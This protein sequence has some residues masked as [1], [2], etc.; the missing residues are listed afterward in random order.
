MP[1]SSTTSMMSVPWPRPAV[2]SLTTTSHSTT[3]PCASASRTHCSAA[4]AMPASSPSRSIRTEVSIAI[5]DG[6]GVDRITRR[7][8]AQFAHDV[9]GAHAFGQLEPAAGAGD[10]I[11]HV[12]AQNDAAALQ[13]DLQQGALGQP[14]GI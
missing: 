10:R 12:L 6:S 1:I 11:V 3:G 4:S 13:L 9:V 14:Q 8:P 2:I 7:A 5:I